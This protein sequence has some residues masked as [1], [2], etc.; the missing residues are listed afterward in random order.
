MM[1]YYVVSFLIN[2]KS[3]GVKALYLCMKARSSGPSQKRLAAPEKHCPPE[4]ALTRFF[5]FWHNFSN[6]FETTANTLV[7]IS[8]LAEKTERPRATGKK[9][10]GSPMV[11]L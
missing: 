6:Y 4:R 3:W 11:N 2:K 8:C 7:R 9:P 1:P 10:A 5:V